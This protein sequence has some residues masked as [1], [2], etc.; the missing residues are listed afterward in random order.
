M[1]GTT[2]LATAIDHDSCVS[3]TLWL[4]RPA[5][6]CEAAAV[7]A[8]VAVIAAVAGEPYGNHLGC[9]SGCTVPHSH[10]CAPD[11]LQGYQTAEVPT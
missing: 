1:Q 11:W 3:D 7:A 10:A 5:R 2:S 9:H 4:T 8:A 6:K